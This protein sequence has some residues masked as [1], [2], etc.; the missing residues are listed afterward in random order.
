MPPKSSKPLQG[1]R[2]V[3]S[4]KNESTIKHYFQTK[5]AIIEVKNGESQEDA[6]RRYLAENPEHAGAHVKIFHYPEPSPSKKKKG[7]IRSEFPLTIR[8]ETVA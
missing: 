4:M 8:R 2:D 1:G 5:L 6:W 3:H 7:E